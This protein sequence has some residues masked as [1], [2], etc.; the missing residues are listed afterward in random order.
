MLLIKWR[1]GDKLA[2]EAAIALIY[3]EMRRLAQYYMQRE[4]SGHTLQATALVHEVYLR[5]FGEA[6]VEWQDRAHFF[7]VVG[8]QMRRILVDHA[9]T[10]HAEKRDGERAQIFFDEPSGLADW[11]RLEDLIALDEA[12]VCLEMIAPRAGKVVEL[13]YLCGLTEKEAADALGISI[14][15][16]KREWSFA[17]AW[18]Y[19]RLSSAA[20]APCTIQGKAL[21][22]EK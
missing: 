3:Q 20:T 12:L 21:R 6:Q 10:M 22:A 19:R 13:R 15:T 2:A 4:R 16:L 5:L 7:T 1:Q 8:R 14:A 17:K 18:L 9:R 11:E